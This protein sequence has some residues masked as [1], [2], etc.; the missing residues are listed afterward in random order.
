MIRKSILSLAVAGAL[1]SSFTSAQAH[2]GATGIIK[3]RMKVMKFIAQNTKM[4][5]PYAMGSSE[6]NF[7]AVEGAA[8][9]I[10]MAAQNVMAKFP[11]GSTSEESEAKPNIWE[12][13]DEF[14]DMLTTLSADAAKL[15]VIAK[16]NEDGVMEQFGK[17]TGNCKS[18][19]TKY[20]QKK[21]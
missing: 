15:S 9:Q 12:N 10:S 20:R 17:M 8:M 11:K 13:W 21:E 6:M 3:E 19:H 14:L 18:C 2:D 5:A 7:K 4:I 16:N 1:L